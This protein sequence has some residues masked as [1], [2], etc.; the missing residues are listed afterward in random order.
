MSLSHLTAEVPSKPTLNSE[1]L[2]LI[3][4]LSVLSPSAIEPY[5]PILSSAKLILNVKSEIFI[6]SP[7]D[8]NRG[9]FEFN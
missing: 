4:K 5:T 8:D 6:L 3:P 7:A 2:A 9:L 1:R